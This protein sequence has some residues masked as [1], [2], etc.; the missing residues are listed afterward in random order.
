MGDIYLTKKGLEKLKEELEQLYK[1]KNEL[2]KEI[3]ET[4]E[5]GDLRENAGYQYAKDK[6]NMILKRISEI[7]N[8]IKNAKIVDE[9]TINKEEIRIGAKIKIVDINTNEEKNFQLVS[10]PEADPIN[11]KISVNS[12]LAQALLGAKLN[13][14]R[15]F[16]LPNGLE[17]YY[18]V[19]SIDY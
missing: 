8:I 19:V 3:E 5:Q 15:K 7:E 18:K 16:I 14:I 17:K 10:M 13:E 6:Q 9:S 2:N 4:R 12:P 11:S 1:E